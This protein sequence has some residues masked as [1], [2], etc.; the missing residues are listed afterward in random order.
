MLRGTSSGAWRNA[1]LGLGMIQLL[2]DIVGCGW[3]LLG[4]A[5]CCMLCCGMLV[6]V[7]QCCWM[8]FGAAGYT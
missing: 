6:G 3:K 8:L 4:V 5:G 1:S 2:L 7:A